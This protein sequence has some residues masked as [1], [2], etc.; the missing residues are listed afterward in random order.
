MSDFRFWRCRQCGNLVANNTQP[1]KCYHCRTG[2]HHQS[3]FV[4]DLF[5]EVDL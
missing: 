1:H 2:E 4:D 5:E 3:A